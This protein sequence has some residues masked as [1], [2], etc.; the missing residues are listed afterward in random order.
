MLVTRSVIQCSPP[1]CA[2]PRPRTL[3]SGVELSPQLIDR[4]PSF[5][6]SEEIGP[7]ERGQDDRA[8]DGQDRESLVD[9]KLE[10]R[11]GV[12]HQVPDAREQML[13]E[14]PGQA[15]EDDE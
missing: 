1:S 8:D 10:P 14:A 13:E 5:R 6:D 12:H 9:P 15:D 2:E 11:A 7:D 4:L 3:P